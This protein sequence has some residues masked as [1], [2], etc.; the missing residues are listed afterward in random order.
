MTRR[1]G[2]SLRRLEWQIDQER[3]GFNEPWSLARLTSPVVLQVRVSDIR[4]SRIGKAPDVGA[5]VTTV[6]LDAGVR[7]DALQETSGLVPAVR[8]VNQRSKLQRSAIAHIAIG[9]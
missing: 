1:T 5:G 9:V 7:A 8:A 6:V 2:R 3:D 4:V